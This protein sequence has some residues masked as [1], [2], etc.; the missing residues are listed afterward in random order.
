MAPRAKRRA[1]KLRSIGVDPTIV[2]RANG[3][4]L[5]ASEA[6]CVSVFAVCLHPTNRTRLDRHCRA[7]RRAREPL[8]PW[9]F[10][11]FVI[12][13]ILSDSI[14]GGILGDRQHRRIGARRNRRIWRILDRLS[15]AT[16]R[17]PARPVRGRAFEIALWQRPRSIHAR[18]ERIDG[19]QCV[20]RAPPVGN[21]H[22]AGRVCEADHFG[23]RLTPDTNLARDLVRRCSAIGEPNE[24]ARL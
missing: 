11:D 1:P 24:R 20:A 7:Q 15:S 21:V 17:A 18:T 9:H 23:C 19:R 4:L 14:H 5:A 8:H 22:S 12:F 13:D 16:R 6:I 2:L 3:A 10:R